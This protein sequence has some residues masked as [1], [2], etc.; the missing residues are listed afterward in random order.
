MSKVN[1]L[2]VYRQGD[3]AF[4]KVDADGVKLGE[5]IPRDKGRVILAFGEVTGHHHAISDKNVNFF[6]AVDPKDVALGSRFLQVNDSSALL[7]HDEHG[8][9]E[10]PVGTYEV[11]IQREY[12]PQGLR[13]VAD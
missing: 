7:T 11:R 12:T 10:L 6:K 2:V 1:D 8:S 13:N 3:V 5:P 4:I 9:I